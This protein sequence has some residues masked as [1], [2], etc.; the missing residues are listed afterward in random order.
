[1]TERHKLSSL[2]DQDELE[3]VQQKSGEA[4]DQ[5][6]RQVIPTYYPVYTENCLKWKLQT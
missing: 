6:E 3:R 1:M 2:N 4:A 5:T